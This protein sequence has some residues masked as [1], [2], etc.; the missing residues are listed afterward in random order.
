MQFLQTANP[1]KDLILKKVT[2][3][4]VITINMH[5]KQDNLIMRQPFSDQNNGARISMYLIYIKYM[6]VI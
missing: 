2:L 1:G 5:P 3:H 4:V 6:E